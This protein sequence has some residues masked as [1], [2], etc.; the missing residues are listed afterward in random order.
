IAGD[1]GTALQL[2]EE[3]E[4][5]RVA[6]SQTL[7]RDCTVCCEALHPLD[8]PVRPPS[9][10]CTHLAEV[11][12]PCLQQWIATKIRATIDCPQCTTLLDHED[13]RRACSSETFVKYDKFATLA[14]IDD[15]H[16]FHWCLRVGCTAGQEQVGGTSQYMKCH[17][18]SFEQC[19]HHKTEWHRGE[20]CGQYDAR[21]RGQANKTTHDQAE[22]ETT[23]FMQKQQT[24][25]VYKK[26]P[27]CKVLIEKNEGCDHTKVLLAMPGDMGGH[28]ERQGQ[29]SRCHLQ[30]Q[31]EL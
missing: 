27:K 26:C 29:S 24:G 15:L 2:Q 3:E 7:T 20:S 1:Y 5:R 23:R 16:D 9:K 4:R 6:E 31:D 21:I 13:V 25:S 8:F 18:C 11:C 28:A 12:S 19:L 17:A 30:V 14:I 22:L 10:K